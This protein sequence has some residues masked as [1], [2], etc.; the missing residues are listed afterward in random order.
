MR[1]HVRRAGI[2]RRARE[3]LLWLSRRVRSGG[4]PGFVETM[5]LDHLEDSRRPLLFSLLPRMLRRDGNTPRSLQRAFAYIDGADR[6]P[7][8]VVSSRRWNRALAKSRQFAASR[9]RGPKP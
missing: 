3:R 2:S 1:A 9:V 4:R 7:A 8:I 5:T 6:A